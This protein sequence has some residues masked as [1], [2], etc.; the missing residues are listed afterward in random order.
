LSAIYTAIITTIIKAI[1]TTYNEAFTT[2][3]I[4]TN[5]STINGAIIPA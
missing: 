1:I 5:W 4:C 3:I 2:T